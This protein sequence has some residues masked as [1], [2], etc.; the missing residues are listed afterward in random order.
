MQD[1]RARDGGRP[2]LGEVVVPQFQDLNIVR[3]CL[4]KAC[5]A[6]QG[7]TRGG[8]YQTK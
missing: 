1:L 6:L 4:S 5:A 8:R 2:G 7:L 3:A